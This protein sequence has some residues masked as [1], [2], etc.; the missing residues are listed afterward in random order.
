[1][2]GR[3]TLVRVLGQGGMG[4]VWLARDEEL[5]I[6]VALKFVAD[7]LRWDPRVLGSLRREVLRARALSHPGILRIHDLVS[8]NGGA[9]IAMEYAPGGSLADRLAA[10]LAAEP[11][12]ALEPTEIAP[13]LPPLAAALDYAHREAGVVHRDLKPSNILLAADGAPKIADFGVS[14]SLAESATRT[15]GLLHSGTLAYMGPQQLHD[16]PPAP[17]DDIY[18]LGATLFDLLA[19][20]PPFRHGDV[21]GQ[22]ERRTPDRI[23]I[24][25]AASGL[26]G[27]PLPPQWEE[28]MARCLAKTPEQRFADAAA[29]VAA[30]APPQESAGVATPRRC[31]THPVWF[32]A[33][34]AA[35]AVAAWQWWPRNPP[36]KANAPPLS[37]ATRAL[38]AWN[39][40]GDGT[41]ASGRGLHAAGQGT[42]PTTDRYGRIDRALYFNGGARLSGSDSP[43]LRWSGSTPFS[44]ALWLKADSSFGQ[45][46]VILQS[47][48]AA[49]GGV[50]WTIGLT[51]F[52][53][54]FV[55]GGHAR[56]WPITLAAGEQVTPGR[57]HHLAAV[58][59]GTE[60]RLYFDGQPVAREPLG[61]N[62]EVHEPASVELRFGFD[63]NNARNMFA[64][65]LDDVRLWRR[66]LT[67]DEV[68]V[69]AKR[70]APPR[71]ALSTA[72]FADRDDATPGLQAEF[73][74]EAALADWDECRRWHADD[75]RGWVEELGLPNI[76]SE[77]FV[78]RGGKL[79]HDATRRYFVSRFDGVVPDYYSVH[80]E[81]GGRTL[82]LGS[83]RGNQLCAVARLPSAAP[84]RESLRAA[85][86]G[87]IARAFAPAERLDVWSVTWRMEAGRLAAGREARAEVQLRDGRV[88][89]GAGAFSSDGR[90]ALM[91]GEL[92][93]PER[94]RQVSGSLGAAHEFTLVAKPGRLAFRAR[95]LV[96]GAVLFV[97]EIAIAGFKAADVA[98]LRVTGV[99]AAELI[100]E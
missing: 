33:L 26:T 84:R 29:M 86:S 21:A 12:R 73:G 99:D 22:I 89:A 98:V 6:D 43:L 97:E 34:A 37:D 83:W 94:S 96:G 3:Y 31:R 25:R 70:E 13:L 30:L 54:S 18:A 64:G 80:D 24:R 82:V 78:Q 57:W 74:P 15:S 48:P 68:V 55:F 65:A 7:H 58:S 40:D 87:D 63:P 41:D 14:R 28:A 44:V 49:I 81:L 52:R 51:E 53:P 36:A 95:K 100:L 39:L 93:R 47:A 85:A 42:F 91:L 19:G 62:R 45:S 90:F 2:F 92:T 56:T 20:S 66:A 10:R 8:N 60:A 35:L 88:L 67:T 17:A 9:A 4:V 1:M 5:G 75:T 79:L 46:V 32:T 69:L 76:N 38:A 23:A 77:S 61:G 71:F 27:E 16:E 50:Y 72:I 11:P 59:D